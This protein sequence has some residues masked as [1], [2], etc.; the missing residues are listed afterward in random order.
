MLFRSIGSAD[1]FTEMF[2]G[3]IDDVRIYNRALS[4]TE[5]SNL[6]NG[7]APRNGLVLEHIYSLGNAN[8]L[9]GYGNNGTLYGDPIFINNACTDRCIVAIGCIAPVCNFVVT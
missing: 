8:D 1:T 7:S 6:Y 3:S 5:I 2:N 9:S 4:P